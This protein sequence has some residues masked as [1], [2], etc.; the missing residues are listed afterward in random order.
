MSNFKAIFLLPILIIIFLIF[1]AASSHKVQIVTNIWIVILL[2]PYV[3]C[4]LIVEYI[5][6]RYININ[7]KEQANLYSLKKSLISANLCFALFALFFKQNCHLSTNCIIIT[8][9]SSITLLPW[10]IM[11]NIYGLMYWGYKSS[12]NNPEQKNGNILCYPFKKYML[13]KH[14]KYLRKFK[15]NKAS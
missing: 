5:L 8:V 15:Y 10:L 6:R 14:K 7:N 13:N 9:S 1:D 11:S 3:I 12:K 4:F 2:V